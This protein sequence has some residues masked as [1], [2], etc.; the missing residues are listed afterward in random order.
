MIHMVG[1]KLRVCFPAFWRSGVV[2]LETA[3]ALNY[4]ATRIALRRGI[5]RPR[6][7]GRPTN[8]RT[9]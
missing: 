7:S 8:L 1:N 6:R 2:G 3:S 4:A 5:A 9:V